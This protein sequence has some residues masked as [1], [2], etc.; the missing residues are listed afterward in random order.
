MLANSSACRGGCWDLANRATLPVAM[1][2]HRAIWQEPRH[3]S[4][5][6][7]PRRPGKIFICTLMAWV[8][9]F[10]TLLGRRRASSG[11]ANLA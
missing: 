3:L 4:K 5:I 11:F 6:L 1:I 2:R 7:R 8:A 10:K 9:I